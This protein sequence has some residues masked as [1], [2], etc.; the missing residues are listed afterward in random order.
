[1]SDE[2]L[3]ADETKT[4]LLAYAEVGCPSFSL[5]NARTDSTFLAQAPIE[6]LFFPDAVKAATPPPIAELDSSVPELEPSGSQAPGSSG[7][8]HMLDPTTYDLPLNSSLLQN[9]PNKYAGQDAS[10]GVMDS[11]TEEMIGDVAQD[12]ESPYRPNISSYD[13]SVNVKAYERDQAQKVESK[14]VSLEQRRAKM[15]SERRQQPIHPSAATPS[16]QSLAIFSGSYTLHFSCI[17][18]C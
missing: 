6:S 3:T 18:S 16:F 17:C 5:V 2:S 10:G 1:M 14:A 15:A 9:T 7:P 13:E 11:L 8:V 12:L 4:R